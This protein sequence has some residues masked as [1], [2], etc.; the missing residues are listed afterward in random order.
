MSQE[1]E[2]YYYSITEVAEASYT[3]LEDWDVAKHFF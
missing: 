2:K 1:K 3:S